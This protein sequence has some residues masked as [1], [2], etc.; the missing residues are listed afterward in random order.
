M[1]KQQMLHLI[2]PKNMRHV[3][4]YFCGENEVKKLFRELKFYKTII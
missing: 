1:A 4:K 3:K 2:I